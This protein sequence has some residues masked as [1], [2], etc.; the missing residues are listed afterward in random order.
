MSA[1]MHCLRGGHCDTTLATRADSLQRCVQ[2]W[3]G[4]SA[5]CALQ[6]VKHDGSLVAATD[7]DGDVHDIA[8]MPRCASGAAA[9]I[10]CSGHV[11]LV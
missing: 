11:Y 2:Y 7:T 10:C 8:P 3:L 5:V 6:W 9:A 4:Y 1:L